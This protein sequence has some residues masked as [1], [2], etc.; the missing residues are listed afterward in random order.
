MDSC[1]EYQYASHKFW[2][3]Y[4]PLVSYYYHAI[5]IEKYFSLYLELPDFLKWGLR[6]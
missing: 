4:K 3:E 2:E 5:K 1:K 6:F